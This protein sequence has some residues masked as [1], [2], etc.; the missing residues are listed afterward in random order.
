MEIDIRRLSYK[1]FLFRET[2]ENIELTD[3]VED[4]AWGESIPEMAAKAT[5]TIPNMQHNGEWLTSIIKLNSR[6]M[7]TADWG[8]GFKEVFR[9][10][11]YKKD[12]TRDVNKKITL[13]MYDDA[14]LLRTKEQRY[15]AAGTN[16]KDAIGKILSD[17]SIPNENKAP[18]TGMGM[19][20][21]RA[22]AVSSQI[23]ELLEDATNKGAGKYV[24]K[25][26]KGILQIEPYGS[27]TYIPVIDVTNCEGVQDSQSME[28]LITRVE[29]LLNLK[30]NEKQ[31]VTKAIVTGRM[32]FGIFQEIQYVSEDDNLEEAKSTAQ[33]LLNERGKPQQ[34]IT[35][36]AVVDVPFLRK[37]DKVNI[38]A[39]SALGYFIVRTIQHNAKRRTMQLE[40]ENI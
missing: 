6:L 23:L 18:T 36:P 5:V 8:E 3:I 28:D 13:L 9:G 35:I 25:S 19:H 21:F 27:N 40:V 34:A 14:H 4:I 29:I 39:G 32:E 31:A 12:Y 15:V 38:K 26:T 2:G 10:T 24:V 20:L 1:L 17:N 16:C 30:E 7:T 37:G 33:K 22:D 11:V